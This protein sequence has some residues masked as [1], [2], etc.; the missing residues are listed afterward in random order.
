MSLAFPATSRPQTKR[1]KLVSTLVLPGQ[2]ETLTTR[3]PTFPLIGIAGLRTEIGFE[4]CVIGGDLAVLRHPR[5][6]TRL[7]R[8][9]SV[10]ILKAVTTHFS[11][12]MAHCIAAVEQIKQDMGKTGCGGL[13]VQSLLLHT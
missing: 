12:E 5:I 1:F 6:V 7:S 10:N 13:G 3:S 4:D 8:H 2:A 9:D 11:T